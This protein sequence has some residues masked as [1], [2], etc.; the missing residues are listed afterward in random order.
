MQLTSRF[1][2]MSNDSGVWACTV[3]V[4]RQALEGHHGTACALARARKSRHGLRRVSCLSTIAEPKYL[5]AM[6]SASGS[7]VDGITEEFVEALG[8][9]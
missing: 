9:R 3:L 2:S 4:D 7:K 1:S 8:S 5:R 6:L